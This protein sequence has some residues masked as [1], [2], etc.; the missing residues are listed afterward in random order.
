MKIEA[1]GDT[2][3]T[4]TARRRPLC[5]CCAGVMETSSDHDMSVGL[6]VVL[7]LVSDECALICDGCTSQLIAARA[8]TMPPKR[9]RH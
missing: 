1:T 5:V 7:G 3:A 4:S 9:R 2:T 8:A 6:N